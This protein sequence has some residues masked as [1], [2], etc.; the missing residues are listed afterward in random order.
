[1]SDSKKDEWLDEPLSLGVIPGKQMDD[2][3]DV[4]YWH[5]VYE[6]KKAPGV[7]LQN[8]HI[9]SALKLIY[10]GIDNLGWLTRK[11]NRLYVEPKDFLKFVNEYLLPDSELLCSADELYGARCGLLHC[12]TAESKSSRSGKI[13]TLWYKSGDS[14]KEDDDKHVR[15]EVRDRIVLKD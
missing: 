7:C 14:S 11:H 6:L 1:M 3:S 9:L 5:N 2:A 15:T 8:G 13:R 10:S 4:S 12:N